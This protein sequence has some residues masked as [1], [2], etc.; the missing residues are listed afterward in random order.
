MK[1]FKIYLILFCTG[2]FLLASCADDLNIALEDPD[3]TAADD[4]YSS[5]DAYYNV[6][7]RLYAGLS[8]SGQSGT[9][10]T[11]L[12]DTDV[13]ESQYIRAYW[14]PQQLT[15]DEAV[16]GWADRSIADFHAQSWT[17]ADPFIQNIYD[18]I[19]FQIS[20]CNEFIRQASSR[21]NTPENINELIAEARFLRAL[22][23]W[24]AIDL[25]GNVPF[26]TEEDQVS[27]FFPEQIERNDLF[28]YIES[29]LLAIESTVKATLQNEYG[30]ADQSAVWTLLT[31]LYLNAEV[32]TG[33]ERYADAVTYA[34]K[35]INTKHTLESNY[36][37]LF[38][39]DN[40]LSKGIIF[41]AN[42]DG[43][44]TQNFG[45]TTFL[46]HAPVGGKMDP[47]DFGIN[48]GWAGLRTTSALVNKFPDTTGDIDSRALFFTDGQTLEIE[49]IGTFENGYAITKWRNVDRQGNPGVDVAGDFVDVDF[50]MFRLADVYLMYAEAALRS[51][52]G[53]ITD[54]V[55]YVNRI[56][57]RAYGDT[58]GNITDGDLTL[59]F[60]LDERSRE[61]YWEGHRRTDLIR[62]GRF[63]TSTYLW[64]WK[65][66]VPAGIS[67]SSH[68]DLLPIPSSDI[69]ANTSLKQND[70]Y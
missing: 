47:A 34:A 67:T 53:S 16:I 51:N 31:K 22:S 39:A 42:F 7:I 38:L 9:E 3:I 37:H 44:S 13:N 45:G 18:R 54:A 62:Y 11:D 69:N 26:V 30:R 15:T 5:K 41:S 66:G 59:D 2:I 68:L 12:F 61:L 55:T 63:S 50:P 21:D 48:G 58:S 49:S 35:V 20:A 4:L 56:R 70:G 25:F 64:P 32:Y 43:L 40:F 8:V 24:H 6:L 46:T 23:Y 17:V 27:F 33:Q 60:I 1:N 57:E 10:S 19:F 28:T 36:Q 29:E 65:G 52:T 14:L